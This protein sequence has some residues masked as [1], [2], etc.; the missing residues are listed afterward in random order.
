M[1]EPWYD[2]NLYAWIPPTAIGVSCGVWGALVGMLAPRGKAKGLM[3]A[4]TGLIGL[5]AAVSLVAAVVAGVTG[6][7]YGVWYGLGLGGGIGLLVVGL[8][9]LLV[10]G[11]AYRAAEQRQMSARDLG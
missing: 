9:S 2:S 4:L 3:Y 10:L 8:N 5:A 1:S 7:P 6:Q 11:P